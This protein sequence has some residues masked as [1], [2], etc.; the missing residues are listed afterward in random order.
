MWTLLIA[1][2]LIVGGLLFAAFQDGPICSREKKEC[3][4][5][6]GGI[7]FL[8]GLYFIIQF[9]RNCNY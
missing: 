1:L 8:V 2:P 5:G 3:L 9:L 7:I 4:A 6:I